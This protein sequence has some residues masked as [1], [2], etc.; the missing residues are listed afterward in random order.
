MKISKS[1]M[2]IYYK[3]NNDK[4][5]WIKVSNQRKTDSQVLKMI[6]LKLNE[7]SD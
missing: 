7:K 5:I 4:C 6:P 2:N 1:R 3:E